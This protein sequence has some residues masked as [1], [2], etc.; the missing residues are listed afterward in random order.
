MLPTCCVL[1]LWN[2]ATALA[3]ALTP[4]M[5]NP[6]QGGFAPP[7]KSLLRKTADNGANDGAPKPSVRAPSRI[8]A[9]P[10]YGV[11]PASGASDVGFDSLNRTRKKQ[12]LYP[13]APKPKI[14]GPGNPP[15]A[16]P[17][18][19]KVAAPVSQSVAGT[20]PGQPQRRRLKVDDD[21]FANVGFHTGT[22]LTKAAVELWGGYNT[23]PGRM[24]TPKGSGFYTVAPELLIAS[25]WERHSLIADLRGSFTGYGTTFPP[26]ATGPSPVPTN[27]DAPTF[28]GKVAGRIDAARDTRINTE[29]RMRVFTDNPGSPNIQ[30]GL[31]QYPLA[32]NIGGTAGVEHDFNRLTV[33]VAGLAD[34]TIY[35][36]S[37][38][39][40]GSTFTNDD[41]NFNQFGGLGR[42]SYD[43]MPGLKPFGEFSADTRLHDVKS[44]RSGYQR[45]STGGY[46]KAGTSFEFSRLLTGEAA[47]GYS[48][49]SYQDPRLSDMKGLLTSASLIWTATGLTTVRFDATSS[50]DETTL[51]GVSGVISRDYSLQVDHAFRRWLIGTAKV[52]TGTSDYDGTRFD[53][54]YFVE[55]DLVYKLSRTFQIKGQVRHDWLNSSANGA[56][57]AATV[58]MLGIRVQR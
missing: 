57:S 49:R 30:A 55:G 8:G 52:G 41:R 33:S 14:V 25:D 19:A 43:L 26:L 17:K 2:P 3:Q 45:D 22:F 38:L 11:P 48:R 54:R 23:N 37:K 12:K 40:D 36:Q 56:S 35:Q 21:P 16:A 10:T 44:D 31:A 46:V 18:A 42:V 24:N 47:I 13:G 34:R 7:D 51:P 4:D 39:T 5:M 50:I 29:L 15:A 28:N 20:F 1:M 58:V 6:A 32:T 27:I 9:I 53:R